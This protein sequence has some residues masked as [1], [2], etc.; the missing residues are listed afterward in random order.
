MPPK[1]EVITIEGKLKEQNGILNDIDLAH[2]LTTI[3]GRIEIL[4][5]RD[6]LIGH[7]YFMHVASLY[8]LKVAFHNKIVP[9]LQEYFYG[10]YGKIGLILGED[11]FEIINEN[12]NTKLTNFPYPEGDVFSDIIIYKLKNI[13]QMDDNTFI[14]AVSKMMN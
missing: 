12:K 14:N 1:P 11:F 9:L 3:N 4:L 10:D 7:S 6:H 13:A 8:D 2:L 5:D